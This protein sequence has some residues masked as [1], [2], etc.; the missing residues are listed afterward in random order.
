MSAPARTAFER[1][2]ELPGPVT[3]QEPEAGGAFTEIH[4]Q[5]ADLLRSPRPVRVGGNAEDM[6]IPGAD[7]DHEQ[8]VQALQGHRAVHVEEVGGEHRRGLRVQELPPHRVGVPLRRRR[9]L[10]RPEDPADRGC[11][12]P[13]AELEQLTLD[14][15]VAPAVVLG[16]EALDKRSDLGTDR[17]SAC[18]LRIRPFPGD[19]TAVPPQ[20]GSRGDQPA[21][22]RGHDGSI[23]P[24][25]PGPGV[26][27]AQHGDLVPQHQ[28]FRVHRR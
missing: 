12:D 9:D 28:Q 22:P 4:Q 1:R 26:S 18:P 16:G 17:R 2:A 7:L 25:E 14:P 3:D 8:A 20:D 23:S 13:V 19:Q 10:Q 11:A 24:V 6:D 5:I 27:A 21:C 15:L